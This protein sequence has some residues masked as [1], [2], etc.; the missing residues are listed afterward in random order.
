MN[1]FA[2]LYFQLFSI[3]QNALLIMPTMD[4]GK[5]ARTFFFLS[6]ADSS[7]NWQAHEFDWQGQIH[8][9]LAFNIVFPLMIC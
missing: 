8:S 7:G 2:L 1:Y 9:A 5:I 3:N 4:Q 6:I